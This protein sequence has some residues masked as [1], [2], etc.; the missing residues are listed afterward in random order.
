MYPVKPEITGFPALNYPNV[1][2]TT[3]IEIAACI[4][5]FLLF[6]T[7]ITSELVKGNIPVGQRKYSQ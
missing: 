5:S 1:C 2:T 6:K 7:E 3:L 4:S